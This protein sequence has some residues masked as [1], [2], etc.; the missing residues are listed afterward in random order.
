MTPIKNT[1]V[2][3]CSG[4]ILSFRYIHIV[5][6][7]IYERETKKE[8]IKIIELRRI[9]SG[10]IG[11]WDFTIRKLDRIARKHFDST[12][13]RSFVTAGHWNSDQLKSLCRRPQKC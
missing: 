12:D 4:K 5:P 7:S 9:F 3:V 8:T 11:T 1:L 6:D 10:G 13:F 2:Y